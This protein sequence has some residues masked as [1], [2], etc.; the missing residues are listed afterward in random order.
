M[1]GRGLAV[2]GGG[3]GLLVVLLIALLGGNPFGGGGGN[4]PFSLGTGTAS[5]QGDNTDLSASCK[6]GA[7]ANQ[8]EDCR[9]VA[10]VNSVQ[11]YWDGAVS[12]YHDAPTR[13]FTQ[14]VSTGCGA[15]S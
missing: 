13:L 5:Q 9:I 14:Q 7:D 12:N 15:A 10:V 2:G 1:G 4:D 11:D 3:A 8:S 6:T